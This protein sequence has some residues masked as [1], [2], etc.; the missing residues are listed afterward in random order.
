MQIMGERRVCVFCASSSGEKEAYRAEA[1]KLGK[2]L[3]E[4]GLGLVYGGA[5]VGLMGLVADAALEHGGKVLGVL[6]RSLSGVEVAHHGLTELV[7]VETMHQRKALMAQESDAFLALPGGFGTLDEFFEIVTWA[8]LR[9][10][11]K[12][13]VLVNVDGYYDQLLTFLDSAV[14]EGF[15]KA[16]N[17]ALVHIAKDVTEAM[18]FVQKCWQTLPVDHSVPAKPAP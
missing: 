5:Q 11:D 2:M 15:L 12:P 3:G 16:K 6:P 14:R 10:H 13:C 9:I 1:V 8:Q 4:A 18:E 7:L 17:R